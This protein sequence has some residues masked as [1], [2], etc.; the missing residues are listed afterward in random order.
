MEVDL[1][2]NGHPTYIVAEMACSHEGNPALA[3]VII[4]GAGRAGAGAIQFQIWTAADVM[5]PQHSDYALVCGLQISR[6]E[7]T[8]LAQ[9]S[10]ERYPA[11]HVIACVYEAA[12]I[13][14]AESLG[15]DAYK[16]HT[17]DLSNPDLVR[18]VARTGRR[19]D[20]SVG[21]STIEEIQA[22]LEWIGDVS[23]APV[24]L[25]YGY[26]NFPTRV[27]DVHLRYLLKLRDLFERRVGYQ[28][29]TDAESPAGFWIPAAAIGMGVDVLEKHIT[30]DRSKRGVDHQAAL[31]PEE[32]A[33]F[34]GM[35]RQIEAAMGSGKPRPFSPDEERYRKYSRKTIVAARDL[36]AG[37]VLAPGDLQFMRTGE[38]GLSPAEASLLLAKRLVR[39]IPRFGHVTAADVA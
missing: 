11:M 25:M 34:V 37:H 27:D 26:Q 30:H 5:V 15:V 20:L 33:Q 22:A 10:R 18:H 23:S 24:W 39:S 38:L 12:S 4:D 9:Y 16:L 2:S 8:A 17:A 1:V 21:A 29:H 31:N 13:D 32:F 35:A 28:D 7:W 3:R 6:D 14:F 36:P 19:I